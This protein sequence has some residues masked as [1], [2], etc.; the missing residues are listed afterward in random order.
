MQHGHLLLELQI[1]QEALDLAGVLVVQRLPCDVV[2]AVLVAGQLGRDPLDEPPLLVVSVADQASVASMA[3]TSFSPALVM[4]ESSDVR[5]R[6][7]EVC[8]AWR[9]HASSS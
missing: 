1:A 9:F 4:E 6:S 2:A 5:K 7:I 8:R 3:A